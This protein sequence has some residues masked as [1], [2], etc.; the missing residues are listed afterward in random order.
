MLIAR[1][2]IWAGLENA[3]P[4]E[5]ESWTRRRDRYL[6]KLRVALAKTTRDEFLRGRWGY[7]PAEE[8]IRQW[9][10]MIARASDP[11]SADP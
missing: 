8:R 2:A 4:H 9:N 3:F 11:S 10:Q 6:K 5:I 1:S 7:S